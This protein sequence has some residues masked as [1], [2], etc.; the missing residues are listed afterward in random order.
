MATRAR[1]RVCPV[2]FQVFESLRLY[3]DAER[4]P[5][6]RRRT[7]AKG[8]RVKSPSRVRIPLSPPKLKWPARSIDSA[9]NGIAGLTEENRR[10]LDRTKIAAHTSRT[11]LT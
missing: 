4:W 9:L 1:P 11:L 3:C 2:R 10:V 5:S 7:P 8:V 6:G